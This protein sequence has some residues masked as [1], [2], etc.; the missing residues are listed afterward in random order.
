M[1]P[2]PE[3]FQSD[4]LM[5]SATSQN[6]TTLHPGKQSQSFTEPTMESLQVD[7]LMASLVPQGISPDKRAVIER[8]V[9][10]WVAKAE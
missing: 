10:L 3:F 8:L 9:T 1:K 7:T 4:S 5:N 6:D 2:Y